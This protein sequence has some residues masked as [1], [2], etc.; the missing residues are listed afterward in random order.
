MPAAAEADPSAARQSTGAGNIVFDF[1]ASISPLSIVSGFAVGLLIGLTG[2]G[3]GSLMTPLLILVFG[4][5]APAAVGTDLLYATITKSVG[6]LVHSR[7]RNVEWRIVFRLA[8]GSLP[9][10]VL[11]LFGMR[12]VGV[13][14]ETIRHLI[15]VILGVALLLSAATVL[16]RPLIQEMSRRR[17]RPLGPL[18]APATVLSGFVLGVLVTISS[19]G[20]GALGMTA[21]ILLYPTVPLPRLV[22]TDIAHAVP[23]TLIAGIGHLLLG[24]VNWLLLVSLLIGSLPGIALGSRLSARVPERLLRPL[25][26]AILV[27]VGIRMVTR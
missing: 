3:G 1:V 20:A 7:N 10:A 6:S 24:D 4:A 2:V 11:T 25:L 19:V 16:A 9:G 23:L 18:T 21:L 17:R 12:A 27:V 22:G 26:A 14:G 13:S 8:A 5:E 15:E